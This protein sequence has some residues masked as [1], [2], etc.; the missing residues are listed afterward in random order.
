MT[1]ETKIMSGIILISIVSIELGGYFLLSILS[2]KQKD[3]E[4]TDFQKV[5]FRAGHAHAGVLV[6]LAII[7]QILA[8]HVLLPP[9]LEWLGRSGVAIAALLVSGGFF[10]AAAGKK[11]ERPNKLVVLIY[12]GM[13][14]LA[15]ALVI[16]GAGLMR[17][18]GSA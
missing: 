16:L 3:L 7:C 1:A 18:A 12:A 4:L 5:M 14:V 11:R 9:A 17:S 2:G 10:A 6:I 15:I 13:L 8:D